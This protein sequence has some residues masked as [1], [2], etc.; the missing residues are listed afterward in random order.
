MH[1]IHLYKFVL[2]SYPKILHPCYFLNKQQH[3]SSTPYMLL[4]DLPSNIHKSILSIMHFS[5]IDTK[6]AVDM[7]TEKLEILTF[8]RSVKS[9]L[10]W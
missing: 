3:Y 2:L 5:A 9:I 6:G 4:Y 8:E 1:T 10:L 7:V